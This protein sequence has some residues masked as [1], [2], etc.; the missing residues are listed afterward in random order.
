MNQKINW[1][2]FIAVIGGFIFGLNMAGI[3]GAVNSIRDVFDLSDGG[4]GLVVSSL[5][6]GCLIGSLLTGGFADRYGRRPV[7]IAVALLFAV[8]S[9]GCALA[10][11]QT[12][13]T[14]FRLLAGLAVGAD[15]VIGPMYIS[16]MA[17]AERRGRMVSL[18][19]FA[20][21]IGILL[22]Y[23]IDYFLLDV[24]DAW[25]WMLAVPA[26]FGVLFFVLAYLF[27]PESVR[28]RSNDAPQ[29]GDGRRMPF[30]SIFRG[31]VGKV[32]LL[33]TLLAAF[34]QITGIN[35]VVN[36]APIIFEQTGVGGDTA[37]LQS[38]LVGLVNVL[39]TIVALWLVDTKGRKVLLLWGAAGMILS[40]GYLV[41]SFS[42]GWPGWG[43]LAALLVYIAFFAASFAPVMWVVT[44][45][46]FPDRVRAHA[47]SFSTCV[48]WI[49]TFLAV[50]FSPWILNAFGGATLFAIFGA[51]SLLAFLF[52]WRCIPE[53]KGRSLEQIEQE[54]GL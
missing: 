39:A 36:Y 25:R 2:I 44:S 5:T 8:A 15:S 23:L 46:I 10:P 24:A 32:V 20:I 11:N 16:E 50:Q 28:W 19:Q 42:F 51:F 18:Q 17:P 43:V 35:A 4:L 53:T 26:L 13:L 12:I 54:L 47:L 41:C 22:A 31:K 27:L 40:L 30:S 49:C 45:E 7:F 33:G 29:C 21:V 6:V 3:S 52:V 34:Q 14:I 38:C 48:S 37:L 9:V 1:I